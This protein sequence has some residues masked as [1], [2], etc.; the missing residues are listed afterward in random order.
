MPSNELQVPLSTTGAPTRSDSELF[1]RKETETVEGLLRLNPNL[2][3][4]FR[5]GI[6]LSERVDEPGIPFMLA[7]A[8]REL[9]LGLVRMLSDVA[10]GLTEE[11]LERLA[12]NETNRV[13][14]AGML[15][16]EPD[17][18]TVTT[19]FQTQLTLV[20]AAHYRANAPSGPAVREAFQALS[21]LAF[22]LVGPY[23]STHAEIEQLLLVARPDET[24]LATV[25]GLL[26]RPIQR[27]HFFTSLQH[28]TWLCPLD[29]AGFF[30]AP[31]LAHNDDRTERPRPWPEGEY[32]VTAAT[33]EPELVTEILQRIGPENH[34]PLVWDV[35]IRAALTLP[36]ELGERLVRPIIRAAR[37][38]SPTQFYSHRLIDLARVLALAGKAEAFKLAACV[39]DLVDPEPGSLPTGEMEEV[40]PASG[41]AAETESSRVSEALRRMRSGPR[42]TEW[43]LVRIDAYELSEL[44]RKVLPALETL[45]HERLVRLLAVKLEHAV[46]LGKHG[47]RRNIAAASESANADQTQTDL[48]DGFVPVIEGVDHTLAYSTEHERPS[49]SEAPDLKND[50]SWIDHLDQSEE[51]GDV[52]EQLAVA[53]A[54]SVSRLAASSSEGAILADSVLSN[55]HGSV[56]TRVRLLELAAA[57]AFAP[58]SAVDQFVADPIIIDPPF[59][60]REVASFLRAQFDRASVESQSR[61]LEMLQFGPPIEADPDVDPERV[62]EYSDNWRRR[63]LRWFQAHIPRTLA[64][65][66]A[67]LD[68][69][70]TV[71]SPQDQALA[72]VGSWS[73]GVSSAGYQS[74]VSV[75]DV[76]AMPTQQLVEYLR[77]WRPEKDGSRFHE[78]SKEGLEQTLSAFAFSHPDAAAD[79]SDALAGVDVPPVYL[80]GLISGLKLRARSEGVVRWKSVLRLVSDLFDRT[81]NVLSTDDLSALDHFE[82][83]SAAQAGIDLLQAMAAGNLIPEDATDDLWTV[84]EAIVISAVVWRDRQPSNQGEGQNSSRERRSLNDLEFAAMNSLPGH[85]VQLVVEAGLWSYRRMTPEQRAGAKII[86]QRL[87]RRA[88]RAI[89]PR[90]RPLLDIILRQSGESVLLART[91]IGDFVPQIWF[92]ARNWFGERESDLFANGA[93]APAQNPTWGAYLSRNDVYRDLF[94]ELRPW[95][96]RAAQAAPDPTFG[97]KGSESS[98]SRNLAVHA[99]TA[100][101]RGFAAIGDSDGFVETVFDRVVGADKNRAYWTVFRTWSEARVAPPI[102]FGQRLVQF[103]EW[104]VTVLEGQPESSERLEEADAL[105]WFLKTPHIPPQDAIRLGLRTIRLVGNTGKTTRSAWERLVELSRHDAGGTFEI[106]ETMARAALSSGYPYLPFDVVGPVLSA[107]LRSTIPETSAA[108][109][110]LINDLGE[111]GLLEYGKLLSEPDSA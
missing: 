98:V 4:L 35:V 34:N 81:Q 91:R 106:A 69:E 75:E 64:P 11:E 95:Y 54:A 79:V 86:S 22:G 90:L 41:A 33:A 58:Q 88:V 29:E 47:H 92:L 6:A 111:R 7:H 109:R 3:G 110:T 97:S 45:D 15:G 82:W 61:F 10:P 17:H 2:A 27:H 72:E 9:S 74:P 102:K 48:G 66:A 105:G 52:R 87:Q 39:L 67:E 40:L 26:L 30:R 49:R 68:V 42:A 100:I 89:E 12:E 71:P 57:G 19:W 78:P 32:L 1:S 25:R 44:I 96:V 76:A 77:T 103:W 99:I 101:I 13:G 53:L 38:S 56:F 5:E 43:M 84:V 16:V 107:A 24:E 55:R 104:R 31:G 51:G 36:P 18:P 63:R 108:A 94:D 60:A 50:S 59:R 70:A 83:R 20:R 8:G 80:A 85:T 62:R 73:S 46:L 21:A 93:T 28:S 37:S 23:F 65:L 14:I